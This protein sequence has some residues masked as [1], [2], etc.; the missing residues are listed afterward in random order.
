M[1]HFAIL[2]SLVIGVSAVC[3]AEPVVE[4]YREVAAA[5]SLPYEL[6]GLGPLLK[7]EGKEH[8]RFLRDERGRVL[9]VTHYNEKGQITDTAEGWADFHVFYEG[10][11]V[12]KNGAYYR[13]D[14]KKLKEIQPVDITKEIK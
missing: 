12:V 5:V 13:A 3:R 1:R 4:Y 2:F 9:R 14:G 8:Y 6:E 10:D 7:P 11:G